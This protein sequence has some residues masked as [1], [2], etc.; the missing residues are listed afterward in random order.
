MAAPNKVIIGAATAAAITLATPLV[1][2]WEG[3]VLRGYK[4][5]IGI[6]T[7]CVGHT[8]TAVLGRTYTQAECMALLKRDM[9]EHADEIAHCITRPL[10]VETHAAF[11]SFAFNVGSAAFCRSTLLRKANAGDLVGAC[12]E[13]PRWNRAGGRELQGLTN[14]RMAE[15]ELCLR[16]TLR[17]AA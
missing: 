17:R 12:N 14:R 4:D 8:K 11:I 13:L 2:R 7:A 6:V 5:P 16:G 3:T 1:V 15:R 10:P 9:Q